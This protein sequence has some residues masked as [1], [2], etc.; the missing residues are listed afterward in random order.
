MSAG[1]YAAAFHESRKRE[2]CKGSFVVGDGRRA[3]ETDIRHDK[4]FLM[5]FLGKD[6]HHTADSNFK[7]KKLNCRYE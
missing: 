6:R 7:N 2:G 5:F 4:L 3:E 1:F